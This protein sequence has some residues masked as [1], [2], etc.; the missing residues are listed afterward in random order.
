MICKICLQLQLKMKQVRKI[1]KEKTM[2][3]I[4]SGIIKKIKISGR[5]PPTSAQ[6]EQKFRAKKQKIKYGE[7]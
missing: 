7:I 4:K 2:E 6:N 1:K 5:S 3:N